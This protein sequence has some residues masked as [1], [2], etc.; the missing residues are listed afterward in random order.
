MTKLPEDNNDKNSCSAQNLKFVIPL[1]NVQCLLGQFFHFSS[2][3]SWGGG[4]R[5]LT[6]LPP[7]ENIY[8]LN[9]LPKIHAIFKEKF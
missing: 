3:R 1:D 4:E 8:L 5:Q 7:K 2:T 6:L 9:I